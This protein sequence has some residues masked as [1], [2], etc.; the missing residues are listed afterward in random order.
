MKDGTVKACVAAVCIVL[1]YAI[2][3]FGSVAAGGG[4]PDGVLF[5]TIAAVTA[6]ILGY[7]VHFVQ[8]VRQEARKGP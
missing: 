5:G 7:S 4:M 1:A 8:T 6:G 3:V 2:Y